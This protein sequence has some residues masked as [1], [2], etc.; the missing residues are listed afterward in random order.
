MNRR[1]FFFSIIYL[2]IG[3][4]MN[5]AHELCLVTY[6]V[7]TIKEQEKK[8]SNNFIF[9]TWVIFFSLT[10]P[11]M[12]PRSFRFQLRRTWKKETKWIIE[13]EIFFFLLLFISFSNPF[14]CFFFVLFAF[15]C[16]GRVFFMAVAVEFSSS[17][18]SYFIFIILCNFYMEPDC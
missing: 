2:R 13:E 8:S 15:S 17:S 6:N 5:N 11:S 3:L 10:F 9:Q 14:L 16:L 1:N 7:N 18:I 4:A 12:Y